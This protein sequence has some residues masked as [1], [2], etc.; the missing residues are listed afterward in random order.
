MTGTKRTVL[1][2]FVGVLPK[3]PPKKQSPLV[4]STVPAGF[5]SPAD[6][7]VEQYLDLNDYCVRNPPATFFV[8]VQEDSDSMIDAGIYPGDILVVDRSI[9]PQHGDFVVAAYNRELTLKELL[10][11]PAPALQAHNPNYATITIQAGDDLDIIGVVTN[12]IRKLK[13]GQR[14]LR[15]D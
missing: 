13:R 9:T 3:H 14:Y 4:G 12:I 5:P 8:R 7:Y 11:H 10:L 15:P 6:D 1:L 2:D